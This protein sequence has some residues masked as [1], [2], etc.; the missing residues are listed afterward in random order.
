VAQLETGS[1]Q[2]SLEM[3]DRMAKALHMKPGRLLD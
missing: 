3:L 1:K 2:C